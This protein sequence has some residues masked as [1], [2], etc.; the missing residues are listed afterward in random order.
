VDKTAYFCKIH[1]LVRDNDFADISFY[2][3]EAKTFYSSMSETSTCKTVGEINR[4]VCMG[5]IHLLRHRGSFLSEIPSVFLVI[6]VSRPGLMNP[7]VQGGPQVPKCYRFLVYN[8][9]K[10]QPHCTES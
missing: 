5:Y 6:T 1:N 8:V 7:K 2:R 3:Y 10:H 9:C 4:R